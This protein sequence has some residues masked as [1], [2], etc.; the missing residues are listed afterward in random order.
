LTAVG[1][2]WGG[3]LPGFLRI[4]PAWKH[5]FPSDFA[6]AATTN[7]SLLRLFVDESFGEYMTRTWRLFIIVAAL[8]AVGLIVLVLAAPAIQRSVFYPKPHGLPPVVDFTMD[9]LL[10][11]LQS[12]LETNAAIVVQVLPPGLSDP[13][14]S[15]LEKEGGFRFSEDLRAPYRW[16]NG[17][18]TNST[19]GLIPGHRFLPLEELVREHSVRLGQVESAGVLQRA[20]FAA[21]WSHQ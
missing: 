4:N 13:Q 21:P 17:V 14:I 18:A 15:T 2:P 10:T 11:R 6:Q 12:A 7:R 3:D 20:A 9:Q 19:L 16:H 5:G 1:R 8:F